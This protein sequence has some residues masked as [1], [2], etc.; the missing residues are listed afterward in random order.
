MGKIYNKLLKLMRDWKRFLIEI[1]Y[2]KDQIHFYTTTSNDLKEK[3]YKMVHQ[4]VIRNRKYIQVNLSKHAEKSLE[5]KNIK[6][7]L[8]KP[9]RICKT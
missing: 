8:K 6:T 9:V 1:N 2:I 3:S 4:N 7:V 5:V